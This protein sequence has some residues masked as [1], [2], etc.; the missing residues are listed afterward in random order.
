ML[1]PSLRV[2]HIPRHPASARQR[3]V[4]LSLTALA[5][6]LALS[7]CGESKKVGDPGFIAGFV[8]GVAADEPR[9]ALVGRDI[10]SRGGS[11]AD[12]ATAMFFTLTVTKPSMASLGAVGGCVHFAAQSKEFLAYDFMP[13]PAQRGPS[14]K[15]KIAPPA[16]V[17]GMAAMQARYGEMPWAELVGPAEALARFGHAV[18]RSL[19]TDI[20]A[21]AGELAKSPSMVAIFGRP[22]GGFVKEGDQIQQLELSAA[23]SNIR[24]RGAGAIFSGPLARQYAD[25]VTA[26]GG[27]LPLETLRAYTPRA[28]PAIERSARDHVIA[29][30]PMA[31]SNGPQQA[32]LWQILAENRALP[33]A[34]RDERLHVIA[35]ASVAAHADY[36]AWAAQPGSDLAVLD[37]AALASV[38]NRFKAFNPNKAQPI[39][40][41]LQGVKPIPS[42]A[43]GTSVVAVDSR[44]NAAACGFTLYRTFGAGRMLPGIGAP[45]ALLPPP[46]VLSGSVGPLVIGN[47]NTGNFFLALAGAGAGSSTTVVTVATEIMLGD[48]QINPAIGAPRFSRSGGAA[49]VTVEKDVGEAARAAL[50]AR[51]YKVEPSGSIG[52]VNGAYCPRGL[53]RDEEFCDIRTDWRGNGLAATA[54]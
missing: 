18:S 29:F 33:R 27:D 12:A 25:A 38:E 39:S 22:G 46:G 53:P 28:I 43:S 41:W 40:A 49:T 7:A 54:R 24:Q 8:G 34:D 47:K 6:S 36:A 9:A 20:E 42:E 23:L 37:D 35:E 15:P 31:N 13:K 44:G 1:N 21:R 14:G 51:G 2:P 32:R 52:L 50:K 10:L 5:A 17:R 16:A 30:L 48:A 4:R 3:T 26:I 45:P 19:A 11:A